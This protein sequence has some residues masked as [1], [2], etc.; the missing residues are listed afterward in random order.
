MS[1]YLDHASGWPP[2]DAVRDAMARWITAAT[3]PMA[4]HEHARGPAETVEATR[5]AVAALVGWPADTVILTGGATEGRNLAMKGSLGARGITDPVIA[6]DPL[7]HASAIAAARSLTR[8]GGSVRM[9]DVNQVGD[10]LPGAMADAATGADLVVVTHGQAEVGC[11]RDAAALIAAVRAVAPGAVVV[12]DAE[13]TAGLLPIPDALGAD[14]VIVGGRSLG[15]PA[16]SGAL[17]V[18]PGTLIHPIIEGGLE[19]GGKRGGQHDLPALAGLGAAAH[20]ALADMPARASRMRDATARLS[21]SL[22]AVPGV[23]LNGPDPAERLPGHAQVS[24]RG[25]EG[26]SLALAMAARGVA[27]S[28]GSA[29][30]FGAGKSSPVLQAMGADDE[31]ARGAVLITLGPATTD[32]ELAEGAQA[33][34]ESVASLRAMA[35]GAS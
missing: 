35:P 27:V 3:S 31:V 13:E 29:C 12:L 20:E 25:V 1:A 33:F 16:W 19:E 10:V 7:A 24:A 18:R 26:E 5:M 21:Q 9:A 34:A 14:M 32:D 11:V 23:V 8:S 6:L 4:L 15:G 2:S 22:L 17:C 28:P 30:T